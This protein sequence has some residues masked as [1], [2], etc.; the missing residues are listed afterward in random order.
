MFGGNF[1]KPMAKK[2]LEPLSLE[3]I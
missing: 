2:P 3:W 1:H